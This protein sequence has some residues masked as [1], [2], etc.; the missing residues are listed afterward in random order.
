MSATEKAITGSS[1]I[2]AVLSIIGGMTLTD[3]GIVVGI[4]T[5]LLTFGANMYYQRQKNA[6]EQHL[7]EL[8]LQFSYKPREE[9]RAD[10]GQQ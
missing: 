8:E 2:G 3:W 1:Y 5:A 4:I 6:R 9:A 10:G 7:Y